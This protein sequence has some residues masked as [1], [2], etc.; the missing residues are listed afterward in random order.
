MFSLTE[1]VLSAIQ[2]AIVTVCIPSLF[3]VSSKSKRAGA[4]KEDLLV[5]GANGSGKSTFI[6]NHRGN[7][8]SL[9]E[10]PAADPSQISAADCQC[11]DAAIVLCDVNVPGSIKAAAEWRRALSATVPTLLIGNKWDIVTDPHRAG[12]DLELVAS[13]AQFC[14]WLIADSTDQGFVKWAVD[15]LA[16]EAYF[17]RGQA[18]PVA[19]CGPQKTPENSTK[20]N[21]RRRLRSSLSLELTSSGSIDLVG[22]V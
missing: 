8:V 14:S 1:L 12:A 22:E 11:A 7:V 16:K 3:F 10:V 18:V 13:R 2:A 4:G 5:V 20:Y 17:K 19:E 21:R 15:T 9:K 6:D